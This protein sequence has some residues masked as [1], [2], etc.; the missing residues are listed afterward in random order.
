MLHGHQQR[1][2]NQANLRNKAVNQSYAATS[3]NALPGKPMNASSNTSSSKNA[4]P[5]VRAGHG[6]SVELKNLSK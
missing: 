1:Y 2:V 5:H 4:R 3:E 6:A